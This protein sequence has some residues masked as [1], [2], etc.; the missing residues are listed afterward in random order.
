MKELYQTNIK[1]HR[2]IKRGKVREIYSVGGNILLIATDRISAFDV[3][4]NEAVPEK[5]ELLTQISNYWFEKTSDIIENH[6]IEK[7]SKN[8]PDSL[9]NYSHILNNRSIIVK[10]ATTLP[11][12]F[13][14]RGYITGSAWKSYKNSGEVNGIKLPDDLQEFG[15]LPEPIFTPTTKADEGHDQPVPYSKYRNIIGKERAEKL[16][17][18]SIKLYNFAHDYLWKR[19]IVLADTKF[20]FGETDEG[21]VILIDEILT[22]DSSRFWLKENYEPGKKQIQFDKQILRDYLETVNWNKM[23]PPP[24]LPKEILYRTAE[25]YKQAYKIITG[26]EWI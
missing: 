23:P 13:I 2:L 1:E 18:I 6:I 7:N 3:I 26:K 9:K 17:D 4:M 14:V 25:S 20:E 24:M 16:K 15:R 22:P 21:K 5:G 8:F 11:I 10:E 12:E 19:G